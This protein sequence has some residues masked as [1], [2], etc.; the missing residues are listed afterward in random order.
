[1][2]LTLKLLHADK[3]ISEYKKFKSP[4]ADVWVGKKFQLV[5]QR[6]K[7][8]GQSGTNTTVHTSA[9]V[10]KPPRQSGNQ[11]TA[12]AMAQ[13]QDTNNQVRVI[14]LEIV[15]ANKMIREYQKYQVT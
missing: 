9:S 13:A 8:L 3:M 15:H 11:V 6:D 10:Q 14:D 1:M 2:K 7:L 12:H 5:A 4:K